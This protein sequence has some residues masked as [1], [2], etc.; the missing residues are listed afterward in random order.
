MIVARRHMNSFFMILDKYC[1][2]LEPFIIICTQ[3]IDILN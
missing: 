2:T 3:A 1:V